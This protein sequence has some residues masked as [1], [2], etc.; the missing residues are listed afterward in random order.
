MSGALVG[1][2]AGTVVAV[3]ETFTVWEKLDQFSSAPRWY[4]RR[5]GQDSNHYV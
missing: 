2:G 1:T 3:T 5:T 4:G